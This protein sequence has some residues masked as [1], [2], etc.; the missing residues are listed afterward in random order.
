MEDTHINP[1][2]KWYL[3][4][5]PE[6]NYYLSRNE[7]PKM[8][9]D[10]K[11]LIYESCNKKIPEIIPK[12]EGFSDQLCV[13]IMKVPF[14]I[15]KTFITCCLISNELL[16][17]ISQFSNNSIFEVGA[18]SG[19]N[20]MLLSKNFNA[21]IYAIDIYSWDMSFYPISIINSSCD[22][23]QEKIA[24]L[25]KSDGSILYIMPEDEY[26]YIDLWIKLGGKKIIT[27]GI[28]NVRNHV[29]KRNHP[30]VPENEIPFLCSSFSYPK[31]KLIHEVKNESF[32]KTDI[33]V[34]TTTQF[35][36]IQE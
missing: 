3:L 16:D 11:E 2:Y 4:Y 33:T 17:L 9:D 29:F 23:D 24:K 6:E 25:A 8:I 21:N 32:S 30:D 7:W 18:G 15:V 19:Y 13:N 22:L 28:F 26:P 35:W 36:I 27:I 12:F 20:A 31:A 1:I 34:M 5:G 14:S 10:L